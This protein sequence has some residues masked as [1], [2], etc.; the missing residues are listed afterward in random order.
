MPKTAKT[1]APK[2]TAKSFATL[3]KFDANGKPVGDPIVAAVKT[4]RAYVITKGNSINNHHEGAIVSAS[5][6]GV[7][8]G[9]MD[10]LKARGTIRE[11]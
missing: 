5:L 2:T 4:E 10:G 9:T 3:Q 6:L 1:E 7:N 11:K 8:Q